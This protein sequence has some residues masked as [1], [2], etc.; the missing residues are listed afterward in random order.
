MGAGICLLSCLFVQNESACYTINKDGSDGCHVGFTARE[1]TTGNNDCQLD[2]AIV[3]IMEIFVPDHEN[4]SVHRL[5]HHNCD[6]A[7]VIVLSS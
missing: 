6:Y 5:F 4:R 3:Q 1:Y 2:G 7:Y